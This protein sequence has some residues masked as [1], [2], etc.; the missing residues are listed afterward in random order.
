[1]TRVLVRRAFHDGLVR[2]ASFAALFALV[3]AVQVVGYRTSYPTEA[4]RIAFARSFGGNDAVRLFYGAPHDLLTVGG[5]VAWR[6]GGILSLFAAAWG[7]LAAVRAFRTEEETG[8][9]ELVLALPV[10]RQRL[11]VSS[12][13]AIAQGTVLQWLAVFAGLAGA[14]LTAS[15]SA[16]LALAIVSPIPLFVGVGALASQLAPSRR[17]ATSLSFGVVGLAFT[18]RVVADTVDGAGWLRWLTP[19]GWVEQLRAFADPRPAILLLPVAI[20]PLLLILAFWL[21][22]RRD[23]GSGLLSPSD[24]SE[25]RTFGLSSPHALALR[26]ELGALVA[27]A[28]GVGGF[29]IVCGVIA[30]SFSSGVSDTLRESI[31][32]LGGASLLSASGALSFYFLFFVVVISLFA[33]TQVTAARHEEAEERLDTLLSEPVGRRSWLLGRLGLAAAGALG[34]GL[35]AGFSAWAGAASQGASV[36]LPGLLGAGLNCLPTALLFL[37]VGALT[38]AAIPRATAVV[39]YGAVLAAFLWELVGALLQAPAWALGISPF[40]HVGLVPT[41]AFRPLSAVVMLALAALA[42]A[43]AVALFERRDLVAA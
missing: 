26:S 20:A 15:G 12:L 1:V 7:A 34:L 6:V 41:A 18:L 5:Y 40:H 3:A 19:L 32:K 4:D 38:F 30:D 31:E 28:V 9:N 16:F 36:S 39:A 43:A 13:A 21:A 27:W 10:S 33:S 25:P 23:I 35:L 8:R 37:S 29:A 22:V 2:T 42:A 14:R 11:F 17:L 24:R